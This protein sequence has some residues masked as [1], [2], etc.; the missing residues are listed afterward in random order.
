MIS[1]VL[2]AAAASGVAMAQDTPADPASGKKGG[3]STE[4]KVCRRTQTTGSILAGK[5]ICHTKAE[6]AQIDNASQEGVDQF[7]RAAAN[8]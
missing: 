4:K 2:L 3:A 8:R 7:R 1:A 6:W 5:P